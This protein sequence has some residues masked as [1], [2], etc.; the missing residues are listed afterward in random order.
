MRHNEKQIAHF[1]SV[2]CWTIISPLEQILRAEVSVKLQVCVGVQL[3]IAF[4][5][6]QRYN[7]AEHTAVRKSYLG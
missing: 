5:F 1:T 4:S 3:K 6:M 7:Y 2:C